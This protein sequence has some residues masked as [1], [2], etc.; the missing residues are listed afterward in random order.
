MSAPDR[1]KLVDRRPGVLSVRRQCD[2][3]GVA[4]SGVYR[5][6]PAANDDDLAL[7]RRLD[8]S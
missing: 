5:P 2:L 1:R 7:M 3:S 6:S 8:P 4:R